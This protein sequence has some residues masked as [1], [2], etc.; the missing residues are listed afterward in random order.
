MEQQP[1]DV[2]GLQ[3]LGGAPLPVAMNFQVEITRGDPSEALP[4]GV[5][6]A[7]R[8]HE[9][10]LLAWL[11]RSRERRV[12][13]LADPVGTLEEA[14]IELDPVVLDTL[15]ELHGAAAPADVLPPGMRIES[16]RVDIA[17]ASARAKE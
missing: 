7:L 13:F 15:R 14:G 9:R 2:D 3:F 16:L 11:G 1:K 8:E 17:R 6:E 5:A 4:G 10:H 12:R